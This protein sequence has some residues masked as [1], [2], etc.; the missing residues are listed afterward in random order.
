MWGYPN[1]GLEWNNFTDETGKYI[2]RSN[3]SIGGWTGNVENIKFRV[4][5]KNDTFVLWANDEKMW[6]L[7]LTDSRFGG[8]TPGSTY[9]LGFHSV[10]ENCQATWTN[11]VVT[12]NDNYTVEYTYNRGTNTGISY[13][14]VQGASDTIYAS[15]IY[16]KQSANDMFGLAIRNGG[17]ERQLFFDGHGVKVVNAAGVVC[18]LTAPVMNSD[19]AYVWYQDKIDETSAIADML[20]QD[21]G[22]IQ[23]AWAIENNYLYCDINEAT[24]FKIPMTALC[25]DWKDGR[26]YQVGIAACGENSEGLKFKLTDWAF[27]KAVYSNRYMTAETDELQVNGMVYDP[28]GKGA[29][30]ST[31]EEN[32][33]VY[34]HTKTYVDNSETA[35][36]V[37]VETTL[38]WLQTD[39]KYKWDN[40][41]VGVTVVLD[42][43]NEKSVQ[44]DIV[45]DEYVRLNSGYSGWNYRGSENSLWLKGDGNDLIK[46]PISSDMKIQAAVYDH[47]F[48]IMF[49]GVT[50]YECALTDLF[51][52]VVGANSLYDGTQKVDIG[53][54]SAYNDRRTPKFKDVN[55]YEGQSAVEMKTKEWDFYPTKRGGDELIGSYDVTSG[56]ITNENYYSVNFGT[57]SEAWEI[58]GT[59]YS[60]AAGTWN[61]IGF[62]VTDESGNCLRIMASNNCI[63]VDTVG[64]SW[65]DALVYYDSNSNYVKNGSIF[66][67]NFLQKVG[68]LEFK[69]QLVNNQMDIYLD[70]TLC[71][72]IPLQELN[73]NLEKGRYKV[74]TAGWDG[75]N[76]WQ[77]V[78]VKKGCEVTGEFSI[79]AEQILAT[80]ELAAIKIRD[81]YILTDESKGYYY[82]YGTDTAGFSAND[83]GVPVY[84]SKN[85]QNWERLAPCYIADLTKYTQYSLWAPEVIKY[86]DSYYMTLTVLE[87]GEMAA[88]A[89]LSMTYSN[90][91]VRK[92]IILKSDR[93]TGG[94]EII[95]DN[96][97][98][99][100][101]DC[102]DGTLYFEGG[103]PYLIYSHEWCC[104]ACF[105]DTDEAAASNTNR[106]GHMNYVKLK[107]DLSGVADDGVHVKW[108]TAN[109]YVVE[110]ANASIWDKIFGTVETN[111]ACVVD[112]PQVYEKDGQKYLLWSTG[113]ASAEAIDSTY[114]AQLYVPFD[115]LNGGVELKNSQ[116]LYTGD[117]SNTTFANNTGGGHG[118]I[119]CDI[120]TKDEKYV[121]HAPNVSTDS[122]FEHAVIFGVEFNNDTKTITKK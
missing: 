35:I 27:G 108:C 116:T 82:M 63:Q 2:L 77:N 70:N 29:Y 6:S 48:Y 40:T 30:V 17:Q 117:D 10:D 20:A 33:V 31:H 118:M 5:I 99:P 61:T 79:F 58:T 112:G 15:G 115:S 104:N 109:D 89:G 68:T 12:N 105:G 76:Q 91:Q 110:D 122:L 100:G 96:V 23:I 34:A 84:R 90:P 119:F 21:S 87:Q 11:L 37:A 25:A 16:T 72:T 52:G 51:G 120:S 66:T 94:F 86:N 36:P 28:I 14:Y 78:K 8:F 13:R 85:M 22:D 83:G 113:T 69:M 24:A 55:V 38:D 71:Y 9:K 80:I 59:W 41:A 19:G 64:S 74:A 18:D 4:E 32:Q 101:H 107:D 1:E 98:L 62:V 73:A 45:S 42:G 92:T 106:M 114:Y 75:D 67:D 88:D 57:S 56:T 81:P 47:V 95:A 49:N 97:T 39:K 53:I 121:L 26:Y 50:T 60:P 102:L 111:A 44:F 65:T 54:V 46:A 103:T 93:P 3:D 7:P 43:N